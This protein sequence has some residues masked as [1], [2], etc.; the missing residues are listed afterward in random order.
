[1]T[2]EEIRAAIIADQNLIALIPDTQAIADALSVGKR[3]ADLTVRI[4]AGRVLD[5]IGLASG[6]ALLDAVKATQDYRHVWHLMEYGE[7]DINSPLVAEALGSLVLSGVIT[8]PQADALL[9]L[10]KVP[11]PVDELDVRKAIWSDNGEILIN[12]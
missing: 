8:Q 5:T 11:D 2:P 10:G 1:M 3:K 6:N 12:G 4:G 7:L 9:A